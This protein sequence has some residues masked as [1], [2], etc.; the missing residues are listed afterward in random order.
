MNYFCIKEK[1][2]A[3]KI[4]AKGLFANA[5]HHEAP[6]FVKGKLSIKVDD[7]IEFL[8]ANKNDKGY[9]NID[10]LAQKSDSSKYTGFLNTYVKSTDNGQPPF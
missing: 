8:Q 3:E 7:F 9:V 6:D 10:L 4:L 5:P 1:T 2:M